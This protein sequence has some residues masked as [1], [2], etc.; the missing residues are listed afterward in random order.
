MPLT[1]QLVESFQ[2]MHLKKYN[3]AISYG[4]AELQLKELAELVRITSTEQEAKQ[5][6]EAIH[7]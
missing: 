1:K 6:A 3:E 4:F 5:N 2:A 7:S